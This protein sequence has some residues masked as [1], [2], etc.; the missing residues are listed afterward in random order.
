MSFTK[1]IDLGGRTALITGAGAGIGRA[2][3]ELFAEYGASHIVTG[4]LSGE[5]ITSLILVYC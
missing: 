4:N 5:Q 3:S 1:R 2:C